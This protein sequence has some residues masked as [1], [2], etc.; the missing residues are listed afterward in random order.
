MSK[1]NATISRRDLIKSLAGVGLISSLRAEELLA[2]T[3][4]APYRVLLVALQHGWGVSDGSNQKMTGADYDFS[5]PVGLA[6]FN[7]IKDKCVVIDA[8]LTLGE[9]GNNH[10][11]SYADMFTGGV[12]FGA[13]SSAYDSQMPL[14]TTPSLDY[15]LQEESGKPTLRLSAGFRSWGVRYHPVSFDRSSNVLPFYTTALDAYNSV[16]KNLPDSDGGSPSNA[17]ETHLVNS[18][19]SMM[20]NPAE[21]QVDALGSSEREKIRRYLEAISSVKDKRKPVIDIGGGHKLAAIPERG[22][23]HFKD[24]DHYLDMIKVAFANN[25]TTSAV[26]G[27]GDIHPIAQ[28][29][30]D[31]AHNNSSIWWD[32]RTQ[33]ADSIAKFASSLDA[34]TDVDGRS[35][36]DNTLIVLSGEVGDGTHDILAKGHILIGGGSRLQTG[37][38][39]QPERVTGGSNLDKLQREHIN[40]STRKQLS[41][42]NKNTAKISSRTN[43]DLL[44]DVGNLAGLNLKEFGLPTQNRGFVL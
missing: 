18:I 43:A 36:L 29:H 28:F 26:L 19:F 9:W 13:T 2:L 38:F 33:F 24:L 32:T 11:L 20:Q 1:I 16:F 22:Q 27:I 30:H 14:S 6:P 8:L 23:D 31:H 5:F 41:W 21:R 37:R 4:S 34:I 7:A 25:M 17:A 12:L 40:G 39:L 15:L 44:R 42:I 3:P 10:D 35:V